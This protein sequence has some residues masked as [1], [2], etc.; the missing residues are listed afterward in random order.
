M[1]PPATDLATPGDA[2][3]LCV[4]EAVAQ[5]P[6]LI[7]SLV[8]TAVVMF[9]ARESAA[10]DMRERIAQ[11]D[12]ADALQREL[13][14]LKQR[15]PIALQ[16]AL[17]TAL[18]PEAVRAPQPAVAGANALRFDHLELMDDHQMQ[19]R[20][21]AAR[22][23]QA[24][25]MKC[26]R[27]LGELD[28]LVSSARGLPS[29]QADRN[30]FRPPTFSQALTEAL[31]QTTATAE[32]QLEW[33]QVLGAHLGEALRK[34][35]QVLIDL[36]RSQKVPA[37]TY[38][39]AA[40][41]ARSSVGA[42]AQHSAANGTVRR[43]APA[44]QLT[45]NQLRGVL[46]GSVAPAAAT[47]A[48]HSASDPALQAV[49]D[50]EVLDDLDALQAV[51]QQMGVATNVHARGLAAQEAA[52]LGPQAATDV[53]NPVDTPEPTPSTA[54]ASTLPDDDTIEPNV[55]HDVVRLLID[56]LCNDQRLLP[57][58]VAW[59][60]ALEA[61]LLALVTV[62]NQFFTDKNHPA[63]RLI[64]HVTERSLGFASEDAEGFEAFF[65]PVE[66]ASVMLRPH[67]MPN[68]QPFVQ[69][70]AEMEQAWAD[71]RTQ[72]L[73]LQQELAVQ[74]LLEVEQRNLLADKIALEL[75]RRDDCRLAPIFV[76]QFLAGPWA[77]V[78]ARAR[79]SPALVVPAQQY[80]QVLDDLLWS[81]WPDHA[82]RNKP[83]L[84]RT[85]PAMLAT[86]RAGLASVG[87][88]EAANEA[89]FNQLMALHA[90]A[91]KVV[92][93]PRTEALP[94]PSAAPATAHEAA[95]QEA[96][97]RDDDPM[98]LAPQEAKNSGFMHDSDA[99]PPSTLPADWDGQHGATVPQS[100]EPQ[101][102]NETVDEHTPVIEPPALNSW[103][104]LASEGQWVRAQL[105]WAS[106]HGTLFMFTGAAGKPYSMT[107]RA[108]DKMQA[109]QT[110]RV[111]AD[112]GL[113][114]GAFD[115]VA[116]TAL[117][118]SAAH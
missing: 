49:D 33:L 69:A 106:P 88:P 104:E 52:R 74:A 77:Q 8:D 41:A 22:M 96:A 9:R 91:L 32:Q 54:Q 10:T 81:V 13:A 16:A 117:R 12:H 29:I 26:E 5:S 48:Q 103:V 34:I 89:F 21:Q 80:M 93:G 40:G 115:A 92:T 68:A 71:Q 30:P 58:V 109:R 46:S 17:H 15:F 118:N 18:R 24:A 59:V 70:W 84:L 62:D 27:E 44:P 78:L 23:Q 20:I 56:N 19:G 73:K 25:T 55:A 7:V 90:A 99:L 64:D 1:A 108:L 113:L 28:A 66:R 2:L 11:A 6:A 51:M 63:R 101:H 105:T 87:S 95:A 107:R 72:A 39:M 57:R 76:K 36:L 86:L 111:I 37:A 38:Q 31:A 75:T 47:A 85:I 60:G 67:A 42:G 65:D 100:L 79:L 82:Q 114:G 3:S 110:M 94:V 14:T 4:H 102:D 61:P 35:Y 112:S 43:K 116:Q 50:G 83:R 45:M 53:Q 98:W 97:L